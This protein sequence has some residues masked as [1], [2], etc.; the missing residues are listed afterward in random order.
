MHWG[1]SAWHSA[2]ASN[3]KSSQYLSLSFDERLGLLV[4][5]EAEARDSRRLAL[6]LKAAKLRQEATVED[7]DFR[8]P[9]REGAAD[10]AR[11]GSGCKPVSPRSG[12]PKA[13][14]AAKEETRQAARALSASVNAP[15]SMRSDPVAQTWDQVELRPS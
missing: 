4:D 8:T 9:R 14:L 13:R 10:Q 7:I 1:C 5:R 11:G 2:C 15:G 6:R 3:W 12:A